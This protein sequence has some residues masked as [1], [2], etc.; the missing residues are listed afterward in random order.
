MDG[1]AWISEHDAELREIVRNRYN[2]ST[3]DP[4]DALHDAYMYTVHRIAKL[5]NPFSFILWKT[6]NIITDQ[7]RMHG[8]R[9]DALDQQ[10]PSE[11]IPVDDVAVAS[12]MLDQ[13][14][15][16]IRRL[17]PAQQFVIWQRMLGE[18]QREIARLAGIPIGTVKTRQR[19]ALKG[20]QA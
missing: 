7:W 6:R 19:K 13:T 4:E 9:R 14:I 11:A 15:Q 1:W 17:P 12:T 18:S 10:L 8:R 20:L 2:W 3:Y 16:A 5:D